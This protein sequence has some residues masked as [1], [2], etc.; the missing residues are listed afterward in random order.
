[1]ALWGGRFASGPADSV[2]ALS[3]SVHFDWRL[4]P[5]DIRVNIAH[6]RGLERS[7]VLSETDA[8]TI[9][10][11]LHDLSTEI[12]SGKFTYIEGDEDVHSAIERGLFSKIGPL[13]GA[14]RAGRSRNDLV[15]TDFKLYCIDNLIELAQLIEKLATSITLQSQRLIQ[16]IAPG[17]THYQH[18]QPVSFGHELAKHAH[19]LN[20]DISRIQDWLKR[21]AISPLGS[22]AL[23]G[24]ALQNDPELSAK[25]LGFSGIHENSI[26][27]VSDRDW[28][29]EL[30][31]VCAQIGLH[32]SRIGE[33]FTLWSST[34]FSWISLDDAYSTGSSIMPQKKNP[35]IAELARGKSGRLIGNLSTMLAVSKGLAFAYNRDLQEDKEPV[36]D[37]FETLMILIPAV[38]GMIETT[39]FNSK[40]ISTGN[41]KGHALATEIAD[42]LARKGVPFSEAH[43]ISGKCVKVAEKQ[44]IEVHEL[45]D[46]DLQGVDARLDSGI[47][48]FLSAEGALESRTSVLSASPKSVTKQLTNLTSTLNAKSAWIA[49][50]R[51]RFSGMMSS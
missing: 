38:I 5:Y 7:G 6:V 43:E 37:S 32:L 11:A 18:A 15:A 17:F 4:A 14:F 46:A 45:S 44:G 36:F 19:A 47:R 51:K 35:D 48:K 39:A 31:F 12:E 41:V 22:G 2:A 1:M 21:N 29:N 13:G 3:R 16:V 9:I 50:E 33:E 42:Y 23:A 8:K 26:D 10:A 28:V 25:D 30:L 34:E 40:N 20:R 49:D 27:A 24:S